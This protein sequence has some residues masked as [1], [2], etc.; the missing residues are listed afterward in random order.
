MTPRTA[1][2]SANGAVTVGELPNAATDTAGGDSWDGFVKLWL[3]NGAQKVWR[4]HSD[5]VN[6]RLLAR[7][8]P[9]RIDQVLKTDLWDEAVGEGLFSA[10][11]LRAR[12][13]VGIDIAGAVVA[14]ASA[15]HTELD[16]SQADVRHLPF[17]DATFDAIVSN[18]TLDHFG[19]VADIQTA[20]V[21]LRRVLR[22]GGTLIVTLDNP[23]NPMIALRRA[24]PRSAFDAVWKNF[25]ALA[26]RMAPNPL[27]ATCRIGTLVRLVET[28]GLTVRERDAVVHCPRVLAVI[29]GDMLERGGSPRAQ[30]RFLRW[31][32]PFERLAA[33]P[34][35]YV[36]GHFIAVRAVRL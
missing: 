32:L 6:G 15:R 22:P 10:L 9:P 1:Q 28:A 14:A 21:E 5:A 17:E 23:S 13:V 27:G 3:A 33:L 34:T 36:T 25:G 8:L 12:R 29:A 11:S 24:I 18:S 19:S 30:A 26:A 20:L 16:A 7:W 35:R 31:L 4:R 2:S